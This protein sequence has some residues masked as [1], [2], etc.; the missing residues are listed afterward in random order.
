MWYASRSPAGGGR[1]GLLAGIS[2]TLS[3][4][5]GWFVWI[6]GNHNL[7]TIFAGKTTVKTTGPTWGPPNPPTATRPTTRGVSALSRPRCT[8]TRDRGHACKRLAYRSVS[9]TPLLAVFFFFSFFC[10]IGF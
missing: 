2:T 1:M 8:V 10:Q 6:R 9:V 5:V 4:S 7:A 3:L